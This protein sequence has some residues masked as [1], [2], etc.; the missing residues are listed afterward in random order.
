MKIV[1]V[2]PNSGQKIEIEIENLESNFFEAMRHF[3]MSDEAIQRMIEKLNIS[4]DAKSLL[5]TLSKSTITVGEYIIK[6]G[7]K[8]LDA[9]CNIFKEYPNAMF[10]IIFGGIAGA[11]ISSVPILGQVIGPIVTPIL[12]AFGL[13][14]GLVLDFQD[15]ILERKISKKVAEFTPLA[16]GDNQ[17]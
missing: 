12:T 14:G 8:I 16:G 1:G 3:D 15:K 17:S 2:A 10:G 5:Y 9:A 7:R 6:I 11:L 13:I 4:A